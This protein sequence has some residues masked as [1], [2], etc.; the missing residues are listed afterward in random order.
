MITQGIADE[1]ADIAADEGANWAAIERLIDAMPNYVTA[2]DTL[3]D[4]PPDFLEH[5]PAN[6]LNRFNIPLA[7][8]GLAATATARRRALICER[9]GGL[10]T[11][12]TMS[13]PGPG[14]AMPPVLALGTDD[15][16][17]AFF[18]SFTDAHTPRFGAFAIT[19]PQG[20]S[21]AVTMHTVAVR[22][23]DEWVIN[24]EK[25]FISGGARADIVVLFATIAP[26][27]GRFGIRAFLIPADTAGF[28]VDRCEDML[29]LRASQLA[30][31]S[32][33]DCRVPLTAMLGHN[34]RRG[35]FI[36]AFTGAQSAWN[37]MRPA[38]AAGINGNCQGMI[39]HAETL[40]ARDGIGDRSRPALAHFRARTAASRLIA[41]RAADRYDAGEDASF[42]ASLAKAFA[43]SLAMELAEALVA[44][45]PAEALTVGSRIEKFLRDAKAYD[46]LEGTGDMQRLMIARGFDPLRH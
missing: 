1:L 11:A 5:A 44:L 35:P 43:A 37:Y 14:L 22:D 40:L 17:A 6:I 23:G 13:M 10:C 29:G 19:E 8:G 36:D 16:K 18:A 12:L 3:A 31:L 7:Y 32:F 28:K 39:D 25:C 38:L 27:K 45:F 34:G 42:D 9:I 21:D 2:G 41:L 30:S 46:I 33:V 15:Q 4:L 26:E 20:G 24:G